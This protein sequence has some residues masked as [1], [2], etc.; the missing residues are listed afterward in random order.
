MGGRGD[1]MRRTYMLSPTT[2]NEFKDCPCCFWLKMN[3]GIKR[4]NGIFPSLPGGMD[5]VIKKYFDECRKDELVPLEVLETG[6]KLLKD[7]GKLDEWRNPFKGLRWIDSQGNVLRGSPD[8]ILEKNGLCVVLDYKTKGSAPTP[9]SVNF[10]RQQL[11]AYTFLLKSNDKKTT[12]F[13]YLL[14]YYPK[15]VKENGNITF[16]WNLVKVPIRAENALDLFKKAIECLTDKLPNDRCDYCR[17]VV[18]GLYNTT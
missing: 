7:Q 3:R 14:F 12:D 6:L 9:D 16:H 10:Y 15:D 13:A 17:P 1:N 2:L 11:E 8:E 4:P 18:F 5:R